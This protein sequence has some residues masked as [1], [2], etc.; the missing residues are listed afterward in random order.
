MKVNIAAFFT[1]LIALVLFTSCASR[2][3]LVYLQ[4]NV[5]S[6][7]NTNYEPVLQPNDV[8]SI[9]VTSENPEVA[10]PYNLKNI[11][12]QNATEV[13]P[14][15]EGI[16]AYIIDKNGVIQF[17]MLGD[18]KLG[19][20]TKTEA[21]IALKDALKEHVKDA[22][23]NLRLLNFK[24]SVLGEV[25]KPGTFPITSERVTLL[26]ALSLAGDLTVYGKRKNI[27]IIREKDGVKTMQ[28]IDITKS[29][30]L[31]SPYYYL[32]QNDVVYVEPNKTRVNSSVVGP[33]LTV[34]ISAISLLVTILAITTR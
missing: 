27:L 28:R 33:N 4:N 30:F 26:E 32:A 18:I 12:I 15:N 16:Q 9:I 8:L 20:L 23:V 19:G 6:S 5:E 14:A 1:F 3:K 2:E 11:A 34:A 10:A 24:V 25:A 13:I 31:N 29:D 21:I 17:P 7:E 22:I